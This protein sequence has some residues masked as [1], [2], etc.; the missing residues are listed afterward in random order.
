[1][2]NFLVSNSPDQRFKANAPSK[3]RVLRSDGDA[4]QPLRRRRPYFR[5]LSFPQIPPMS[6]IRNNTDHRLT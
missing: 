4:Y 6:L 5:G 3:D 1:M 2:V